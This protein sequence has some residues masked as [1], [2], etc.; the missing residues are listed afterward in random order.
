[1]KI[2]RAKREDLEE[3]QKLAMKIGDGD[4]RGY[5]LRMIEEQVVLVAE[6]KGKIIGTAYGYSDKKEGWSEL[7]GIVVDK[8]YRKKGIGTALINGIEQVNKGT[9]I[10]VFADKNT[11][12][13]LLPKLG[14][15]KEGEYI[16]FIKV[17]ENNE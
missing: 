6:I 3:I 4:F 16:N 2:R 13:K 8:D 7:R 12:A 5:L 10:E 14:Y 17:L 1:M 15:K 11:L 9:Q